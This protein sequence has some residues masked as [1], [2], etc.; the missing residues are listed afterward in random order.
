MDITTF[1]YKLLGVKQSLT[2]EPFRLSEALR[3]L[4]EGY[5]TMRGFDNSSEDFEKFLGAFV[6]ALAQTDGV[7]PVYLVMPRAHMKWAFDQIEV[8]SRHIFRMR[9]GQ[10]EGVKAIRTALRQIRA[11]H[12][13]VSEPEP[14]RWV[15]FGFESSDLRLPSWAKDRLLSV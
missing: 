10:R 3:N 14:D 13:V 2:P 9:K 11:S 12:Q 7:F 5:P 8:I 1:H 4:Y 6:M 15:M